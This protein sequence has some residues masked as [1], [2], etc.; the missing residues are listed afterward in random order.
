MGIEHFVIDICANDWVSC[1]LQSEFVY[2]V[3]SCEIN[4]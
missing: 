1:V 2:V 3:E 4:D